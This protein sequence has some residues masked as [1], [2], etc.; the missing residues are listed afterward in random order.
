MNKTIVIDSEVSLKRLDIDDANE[1]FEL[2]ERN[3]THLRQWLPWL[4]SISNPDDTKEFIEGTIKQF[5]AGLGPVFAIIVEQ[6]IAGVIGFHPIDNADHVAE[7]GYWLSAD[8]QGKGIITNSCRALIKH[9]FEY[10]SVNRLQVPAAEQNIK[11]RSVSERLGLKF[12]G[13]LRERENLY[14]NFV[15]HAMYSILKSEYDKADF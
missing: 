7:I 6:R 10:L 2:T 8:H 14:G 9:A 3:R 11:S 1:L 13:I 5:E 12:E 4:D 15:N